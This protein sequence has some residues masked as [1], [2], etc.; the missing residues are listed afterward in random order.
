MADLKL[1]AWEVLRVG[2]LAPRVSMAD[3]ERAAA[4]G[5]SNLGMA[6]VRF[7]AKED[8][9]T[10]DLRVM[11]EG[12]GKSAEQLVEAARQLILMRRVVID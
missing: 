5:L 10:F 9:A 11:L 3:I 1:E 4:T 12:D 8:G 2:A 6:C 7:T